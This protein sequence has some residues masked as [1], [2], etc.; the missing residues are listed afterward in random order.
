MT[1]AAEDELPRDAQPGDHASGNTPQND[2]P[3]AVV[4]SHLSYTF[5]GRPLPSL[6]D[7]SFELPSGSWTLL[8]G[9]SGSGKSTLLRALAGWIPR[10]AAGH[11]RGSVLVHGHDTPRATSVQLAR[12]AGLV[13]QSADEQLF[14]T[15]VRS[16]IAFGLENLAWMPSAIEERIAVAIERFGLESCA[17]EPPQQ[18]S[19][20]QKQR[21][22]LAAIWAMRPAVLM[23]DEPLTQL[24]PASAA[25]LL[26]EL[27]RLRQ[28]GMTIVVAEH[29]DA[30]LLR[31]VDR[32]ITL[33]NGRLAGDQPASEAPPEPH[34]T[35]RLSS[36]TLATPSHSTFV[37]SISSASCLQVDHLTFAFPGQEKPLWSDVS[38]TVHSPERIALVGP[39][40][41]GKS[42]LLAV[43]AGLERPTGGEV[44]WTA[45]ADQAVAFALLPQNPDLL[46]FRETVREELAFGPEQLG[47][48][49]SAIRERILRVADDLQIEPLLVETP[50]ALSQGQRLRVA[51]AS[52]LTLE[53]RVLLL[54]EPTTGQDAD[55]MLN[56]LAALDRALAD[57]RLDAVI[58]ATHEMQLVERWANR[59]LVLAE[60][61]LLADM[62]PADLLDDLALRRRARLGGSPT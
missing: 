17:D 6:A 60:G 54:D 44:F 53:P 21:V 35:T 2:L 22:L 62:K 28:E 41:S 50:Q 24:D 31:R 49:R 52:L 30:E 15:T 19:G 58:V 56:I 20:G 3:P 42:T 4:V 47:L 26:D 25:E 10:H 51:L 46:L 55:N 33:Q 45:G 61:R 43:L 59:V 9:P 1:I 29:R 32:V 40:G 14:A 12:S 34:S 8:A 11:M 7:I 36:I 27:A 5:A 23:L 37:P 57:R 13:L 18:L 48:A 16:E 38:L 39:N